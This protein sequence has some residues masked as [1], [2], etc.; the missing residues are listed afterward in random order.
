M[1]SPRSCQLAP[2]DDAA[3][4]WTAGSS[5]R[6]TSPTEGRD[7]SSRCT[8][9]RPSAKTVFPLLFSPGPG[10]AASAWCHGGGQT[11]PFTVVRRDSRTTISGVDLQQWTTADV[12]GPPPAALAV[13]DGG[14]EPLSFRCPRGGIVDIEREVAPLEGVRIAAW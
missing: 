5:Y 1:A 12:H 11:V 8:G 14:L 13:R 4:P 2:V 3:C 10:Q 9:E 7:S 6:G